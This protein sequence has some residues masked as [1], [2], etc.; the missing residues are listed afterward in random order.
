MTKGVRTMS[1]PRQRV[2]MATI[3]ILC[4][5]G[6]PVTSQARD[7]EYQ[8][9]ELMINVTPGEPT[10]IQFP[11]K[12]EQG[13]KKKTSQLSIER[14][15]DVLIIVGADTLPSTGEVILVRL[16]D[17]RSYS[18]RIVKAAADTDRDAIVTI[19]DERGA[20]VASSDEEEPPYREKNFKYAAP[21]QVSG[22]LRE[23]VLVAELGKQNI[24]GYRASDAHRGEKVL[25]DGTMVATIDRIFIGP[26]LWG[27]VL[28]AQNLLDTNQ[29]VNPAT[30]RLDGTRAVSA[31][32]WELAA[33]PLN[34][35]QQISNKDK[36]KIYIITRAKKAE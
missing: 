19:K 13:Y 36:T 15:N 24:T 34:I 14:R 18:I 10:E 22:L 28:D 29:L 8:N 9:A 16:N 1:S 20:L 21:T 3:V 6:L 4:W 33:R 7:V 12:I 35:E 23:M 5:L 26:T 27:Y 32:N 2:A 31:T 11:G 30:F 25:D 17:G